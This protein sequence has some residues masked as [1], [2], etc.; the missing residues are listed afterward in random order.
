[1]DSVMGVVWIFCLECT[2][3]S[4][5]VSIVKCLLAYSFTTT[6]LPEGS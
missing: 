4:T 3:N 2:D 6:V 1:M 5:N